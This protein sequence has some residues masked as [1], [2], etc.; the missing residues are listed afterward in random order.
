MLSRK[1]FNNQKPL[2]LTNN[3]ANVKP[4]YFSSPSNK[5]GLRFTFWTW[6]K[7]KIL[8]VPYPGP[9]LKIALGLLLVDLKFLGLLQPDLH[10][11]LQQLL[12]YIPWNQVYPQPHCNTSFPE[13]W[14]V[15][16]PP[17]VLEHLL[18]YHLLPCPIL[19]IHYVYSFTSSECLLAI[20]L[21]LKHAELFMEWMFLS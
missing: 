11:H 4:I 10:C 17:P 8:I 9:S 12:V 21:V 16:V 15:H 18:S 14:S 3:C 2:I 7:T 19:F 13:L 1:P 6:L 20:V 5:W